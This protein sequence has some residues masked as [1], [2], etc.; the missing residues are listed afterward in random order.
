M[1]ELSDGLDL[2]GLIN[3]AGTGGAEPRSVLDVNGGE[4]HL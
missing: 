4:S 1:S 3:N 2:R